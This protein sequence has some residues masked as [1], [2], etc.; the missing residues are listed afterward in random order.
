MPELLIVSDYSLAGEVCGLGLRGMQELVAV[1][2]QL[3]DIRVV[4]RVVGA[5][6]SLGLGYQA[7]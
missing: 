2:G 3:V 7:S 6:L 5:V 4:E 1:L